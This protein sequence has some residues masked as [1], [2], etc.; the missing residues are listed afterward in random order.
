MISNFG[1]INDEII[2]NMKSQQENNSSFLLAAGKLKSSSVIHLLLSS[3]FGLNAV[4]F[5]AWLGYAIGFWALIIQLAWSVSFFLLIPAAKHFSK[6]ESLHDFLGQKFGKTTR[7]I[8]ALCSLIGINYLIAWEVSIDKAA[9]SPLISQNGD[10]IAMILIS[11]G[12]LITLFYTSYFGLKGNAIVDTILNFTKILILLFIFGLVFSNFL[13]LPSG[14]MLNSIFP[15]FSK[16]VLTLGIVGFVTNIL[17]SLFWQLVDNSSWQSIIGGSNVSKS[18]TQNNLKLS[19]FYIFLFVNFLATVLGICLSGISNVTPDNILA[20]TVGIIPS[21]KLITSIGII[22]LSI[23]SLMSLADGMLLASSSIISFDI[24]PNIKLLSNKLKN[25]KNLSKISVIIF[26]LISIWGIQLLFNALKLN[27]FELVYIIIISQLALVGP[28]IVGIMS[29]K[30]NNLMFIPILIGLF[31]GFG[32]SIYGI[33]AENK[34]L[35]D[36]AGSFTIISSILSSFIFSLGKNS[37]NL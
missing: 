20:L 15:P 11:L 25:S 3:S 2:H 6:V 5:A 27:L 16:V 36:G 8:A 22:L 24:F 31:I 12:A 35:I 32:S 28:V 30:K 18:S 34:I 17:F 21:L 33:I 10:L 13:K 26:G 1:I 7:V 37:D 4:F 19:G 23:F 29:N 9:I 14:I